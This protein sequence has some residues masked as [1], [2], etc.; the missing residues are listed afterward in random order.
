[1]FQSL[2]RSSTPEAENKRRLKMIAKN[3]SKTKFHNFYKPGSS[4]LLVSFAKFMYEIYKVVS[5]VQLFFVNS[6]NTAV[7]NRQMI[8]CSLSDAQ[9]EVLDSLDENNITEKAQKMKYAELK[10]AVENAMEKFSASFDMGKIAEIE[11]LNK[12]FYLFK[13]FCCFDYYMVLK[14]FSS[15]IQEHTFSTTPQFEN[16][17]AEYLVEELK[18]FASVAYVITGDI[19]W[20]PLFDFFKQA[21]G[22]EFVNV[23]VWKKIVLRIKSLQASGA[24]DMIIQLISK[25]P[26]YQT[27]I[28]DKTSPIAEPFLDK[29][30]DSTRVILEKIAVEQ[31][32]TKTSGF[33][34]QIFGGSVSQYLK[35]YTDAL[36]GVLSKKELNT[37][38]YTEPLNLLKQFIIE[39]VKKEVHQYYDVVVIRGQW[40]STLA[41][42]FSNSYQELLKISEGI[43]AFDEELAETGTVGVKIKTLL[44]KTAHDPGAENIINRIVS[45]SD[46]QARGFLMT[47]TH[48]FVNIGKTMKQLIEDYG[49]PKA[50]IVQNWHDLEK[51]IDVPMKDFS[52]N[53]YKKLYLFVQMMQAYL[54]E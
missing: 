26:K 44:P 18:D 38:T 41:S 7:F 31:K 21:Y 27:E 11:N 35:N 33:A 42:P 37:F 43:T 47:A 45:D 28:N 20:Q 54:S 24:L 4:E 23:N 2:F 30:H 39:F 9:L 10:Q 22:K 32:N 25:D 15:S 48:D 36:N 13:D 52:I 46:E 50:V 49:R 19:S 53:I 17:N 6:Q 8:N 34:Q 16:I 29:L 5:P 14:K 3:L 40:D 51:F 12:A 1:M